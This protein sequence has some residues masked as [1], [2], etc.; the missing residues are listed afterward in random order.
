VKRFVPL[1]ALPLLVA[2]CGHQSSAPKKL[3]PLRTGTLPPPPPLPTTAHSTTARQPT[4]PVGTVALKLYF[5]RDG[6]LAPV[7]RMVSATRS[8]GTAA[9][10]AL[11]QGP[12]Q[13]ERAAGLKSDVPRS[14]RPSLSVDHGL[15]EIAPMQFSEPTLA[16]FVYT[17]TE[18][19]TI[20]AV[21]IGSGGKHFTRASLARYLP[22][23][24]VESPVAGDTVTSPLHVS[25]T[26]N[27]FEG[28]F[29]VELR[30]GGQRLLKQ[31]VRAS[32]GSGTRGIF[33]ASFPF[34]VSRAAQ[35]VVVAYDLSPQSGRPI[36]VVRIPVRVSP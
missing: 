27:T 34:G 33:D 9:L 3:P 1:L 28:S 29:Q 4:V 32:S 8:V 30:V 23:I 36:D 13:Q 22:A 20:H 16:Q 24:L 18:F 31:T 14:Y 2:A 6:K 5:L 15:A 21:E 10:T 19:P 17:L 7:L 11:A 35:G 25:G 12:T 26:A